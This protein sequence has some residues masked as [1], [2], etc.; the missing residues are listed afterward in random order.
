[1]NH[2]T[3]IDALRASRAARHRSRPPR[4]HGVS[5]G[6]RE[7]H[8]VCRLSSH[9][10]DL[11]A[12]FAPDLA[13]LGVSLRHRGDELLALP[14]GL[15]T[16]ARTGAATGIPLLHP[17]A[18]RLAGCDYAAAGRRVGLAGAAGVQL[19][20]G[21]LPIHGV[22]GGRPGFRVLR[23]G[24]SSDHAWLA[25]ELDYGA[26]PDLLAAFPYPHRLRVDVELRATA[27]RIRTTLV[28]TAPV[29]VP[30]AF[31]YH[32][33][34]QLPGVAREAWEVALPARTHLALDPR[35]LPTGARTTLGAERVPLGDSRFDDLFAVGERPVAFGLAGGGR[36][37][38]VRLGSGYPYAQVF[39][40]AGQD[41]VCFEPMTAPVNALRSGQ[42]L[43][44]AEPGATF[45]AEWSLEVRNAV[46]AG[47]TVGP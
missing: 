35:G 15:D 9:G 44:L 12:T 46:A 41:L 28:P 11:H 2:A 7:E 24:A 42:G 40:P 20:G 14:N 8:R 4:R 3:V 25:A 16:Y 13:M 17:W 29:A 36:E 34:L 43:R 39:A 33:Y 21:G 45:V 27:L 23:A 22:V 31:G 1:M 5:G 6:M 32:P 30:V 26:R 47:G 18:N 10:H 19:D 38:T 37:L